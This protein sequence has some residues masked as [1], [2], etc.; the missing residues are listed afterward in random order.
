MTTALSIA[1][2]LAG[3][4]SN[5]HI[6]SQTTFSFADSGVLSAPPSSGATSLTAA[7][8]DAIRNTL[9]SQCYIRDNPSEPPLPAQN[10]IPVLAQANQTPD[11]WDPG[12]SIYQQSPDG[13][14][15]VQ[16]G[17]RSRS[18]VVG[19]YAAN[20]WP[21]MAPTIGE[22]VN[23]RIYPGSAD[24]QQGF[25]YAFGST[26]SDQFD[27]YALIRFYFNIQAAGAA[28]LLY[29]ITW[30]FNRYGLPFRFK[31]LVDASAY[32][33]ADAAVLYIAKRYFTLA[34]VLVADIRQTLGGN[35]RSATPL[36]T[37]TLVDGIGVAEEPGTGE[38]FGMHRCRLVAEGIVDA[39]LVGAQTVAARSEAVQKRFSTTGIHV[40]TPYLNAYSVNLFESTAFT[41]GLAL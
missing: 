38:S 23:I 15:M 8:V 35:I 20:K 29:A 37:H 31:T 12:W 34:A 1:E 30:Q 40:Q 25:Y 22:Q 6:H 28:D 9:Y 7:L 3:I 18:A 16:K 41:E 39:W 21:G 13:R 5:L 19:E 10:L 26:L 17:E 33:R 2:E 32:R 36:F 11:R 27:E 4:Y 14:I 24:M